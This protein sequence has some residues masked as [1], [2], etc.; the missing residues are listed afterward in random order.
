MLIFLPQRPGARRLR[1]QLRARQVRR[2]RA[3]SRLR[4]GRFALP[5]R[6]CGEQPGKARRRPAP[7][8][9]APRS[10]AAAAA[11]GEQPATAAAGTACVA[12]H[13]P[14]SSRRPAS[15][16]PKTTTR[17]ELPQTC[18]RVRPCREPGAR[19]GKPSGASTPDTR[20]CLGT[21]RASPRQ[22]PPNSSAPAFFERICVLRP[23]AGHPRD[24]QH[25]RI[26]TRA[27]DAQVGEASLHDVSRSY[28]LCVAARRASRARG[29][30][31]KVW[32]AVA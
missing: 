27:R 19:L 13:V 1:R 7:R 16:L 31:Q 8:R 12:G 25:Q 24:Q 5:A 30:A 21:G 10:R 23:A 9:P 3:G 15:G 11:H 32:R 17:Q 6:G 29:L 14:A 26:S 22:R 4:S 28:V 18:P 20:R 2:A